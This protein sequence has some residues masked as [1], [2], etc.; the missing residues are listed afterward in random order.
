MGISL[1]LVKK[2]KFII[3]LFILGLLLFNPQSAVLADQEGIWGN[4]TIYLPEDLVYE[5][6]FFAAGENININAEMKDDVYLA[7]ANVVINGPVE[8]D[9]I[10]I[11][12]NVV[13]NAEVKGNLRVA[14]SSVT[15]KGNVIKNVTA[16]GGMI[17][18]DSKA[19]IGRN[20]LIAGG[21]VEINGKVNKNLYGAGGQVILNNEISGSAYL[22]IDPEGK[23]ILY[24]ETNVA[25]NLEYTARQTAD[26]KTGAKIGN[27]E[28]FSQWQKKQK[29]TPNV[30]VL[31]WLAWLV[32]LL[33]TIIAGLV[34]VTLFK[35][36][37][38][39][40]Q[41]IIDKKVLISILKGFVYLI[42]TPFVLIILAITLIGLPLAF[43]LGALYFI[44]L[45]IS[46]IF[47]AVFVGEKIIKF[48]NK[49]QEAQLIWS[50]IAGLVV[51]FILFSI[52]YFGWLIKLTVCLWGL[53]VLMSVIKN[54]LNLES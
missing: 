34:L 19:E 23:L 14:G 30:A 1:K 41:K 13:I 51:L 5:N 3:L 25:G 48:F 39:K 4:G 10:A 7:G 24:P 26:I 45:Y 53:G 27:E 29:M 49:K 31:K 21:I 37:I 46:K 47:V 2:L 52:P 32:M 44:F 40:S 33:G 22:S 16:A 38:L 35:E 54:K 50:M 36:L 20:L 12:S 15:I 28:K 43:I 18:V 42:V 8:G 9:I 11:G 6:I 17:T